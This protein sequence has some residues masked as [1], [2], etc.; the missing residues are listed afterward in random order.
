MIDYIKPHPF[1]FIIAYTY[2]DNEIIR[3]D[4]RYIQ[5]ILKRQ[6]NSFKMYWKAIQKIHKNKPIIITQDIVL[7][8]LP[9]KKALLRCHI[10]LCEIFKYELKESMLD[11]LFYSGQSLQIP[12]I[13]FSTFNRMKKIIKLLMKDE[14]LSR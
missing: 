6:D 12:N 13:K 4:E 5:S 9:H 10:N 3:S 7:Y 2:L 11:I 1:G 8:N 14:R